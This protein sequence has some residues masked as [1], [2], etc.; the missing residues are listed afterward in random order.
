[1][2]KIADQSV[3]GYNHANRSIVQ[4]EISR[5]SRSTSTYRSSTNHN[6]QHQ[7]SKHV[8]RSRVEW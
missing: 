5:T 3:F 1:M 4:S 6:V 2:V 7:A 8:A